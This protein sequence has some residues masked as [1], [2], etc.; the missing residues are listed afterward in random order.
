MDLES[1]EV[2]LPGEKEVHVCYLRTHTVDKTARV[3]GRQNVLHYIHTSALLG[4][5]SEN[6]D[7]AL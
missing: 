1:M 5:R 3:L 7:T 4:E 2:L 6:A